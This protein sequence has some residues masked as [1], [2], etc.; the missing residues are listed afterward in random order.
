MNTA[1]INGSS[2]DLK[3]FSIAAVPLAV[4]TVLSPLLAVPIFNFVVGKIVL[5]WTLVK[6]TW[7]WVTLTVLIVYEILVYV[8]PAG[9]TSDAAGY[10]KL[11]SNIF[12]HPL[13]YTSNV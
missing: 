6:W 12:G 1:Q 8:G 13:V 3:Y 11:S 7:T 9:K 10:L 4:A 2:W 5:S